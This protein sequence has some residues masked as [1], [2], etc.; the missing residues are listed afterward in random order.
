MVFHLTENEKILI[1]FIATL[2]FLISLL[3]T[4]CLVTPTCLLNRF[5]LKS[6]TDVNLSKSTSEIGTLSKSKNFKLKLLPCY[7]SNGLNQF[8]DLSSSQSSESQNDTQIDMLMCD[9]PK[10]DLNEQLEE[11]DNEK[12][13]LLWAIVDYNIVD[14]KK[15]ELNF[16]IDKVDS[17][18]L[19]SIGLE[20]NCYLVI[21][22]GTNRLIDLKRSSLRK[23]VSTFQTPIFKRSLCA[24]FLQ[25]FSSQPISKSILKNGKIMI[26]LMEYNK[27]TNDICLSQLTIPLK[28]IHL[29]QK[30]GNVF[31]ISY[32][33]KPSKEVCLLYLLL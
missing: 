15:I 32:Q 26:K 4:I 23:V 8:N 21:D 11:S 14:K 1:I 18:H 25:Q 17:I 28:D 27:Y 9:I 30:A 6:K 12:C 13:P 20:P 3:V 19:N 24:K 31:P 33:M 16:F 7:G 29:H 2:F 22:V 10:P 5:L